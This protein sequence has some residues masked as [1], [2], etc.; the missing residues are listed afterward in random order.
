M[1]LTVAVGGFAISNAIQAESGLVTVTLMGIILTN[2][3]GLN[4]KP[5]IDFKENLGVLLLSV[6]FI[7]LSARLSLEDLAHIGPR[8]LVFLAVLIFVARPASVFFAT[9]G[10]GLKWA[11]KFS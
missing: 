10:S 9:L 7:I 6:L 11:K 4:I 8:S 5:I 3:K 1:A 2:Q